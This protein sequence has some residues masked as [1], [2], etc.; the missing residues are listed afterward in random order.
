MA[1]LAIMTSVFSEFLITTT[2]TKLT[3]RLLSNFFAL[4][5]TT[6]S[7][8]DVQDAHLKGKLS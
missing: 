5:N 4:P 2:E 3:Q 6:I 8:I 1:A 7:D